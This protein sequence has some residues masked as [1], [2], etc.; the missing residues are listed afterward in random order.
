V[1]ID[2]NPDYLNLSI[3]TRLRQTALLE[4]VNDA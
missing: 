2:I 3:R 1:G 4:Q